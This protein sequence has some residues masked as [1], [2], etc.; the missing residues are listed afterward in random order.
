V[1]GTSGDELLRHRLVKSLFVWCL[2]CDRY[3]DLICDT[4][5][6]SEKNVSVEDFQRF[7]DFL[8]EHSGHRLAFRAEMVQQKDLRE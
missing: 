3:H 6:I 8:L 5:I 7:S 1:D 2:D 4:A